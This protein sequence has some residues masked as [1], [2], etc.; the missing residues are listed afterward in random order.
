MS[1]RLC[2]QKTDSTLLKSIAFDPEAPCDGY[3]ERLR[4]AA[5]ACAVDE[6]AVLATLGALVNVRRWM[7]LAPDTNANEFVWLGGITPLV[8]ILQAPW[9]T[10]DVVFHALWAATNISAGFVASHHGPQERV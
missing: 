5:D 1:R 9:A 10:G 3:I 6:A 7:D 4:T 2:A 8:R